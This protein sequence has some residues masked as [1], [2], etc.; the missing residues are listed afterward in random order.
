[1]Y[2]TN[3]IESIHVSFRKVTKKSSIISVVGKILLRSYG[4]FEYTKSPI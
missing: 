2:T 3:A 4:A 1:M